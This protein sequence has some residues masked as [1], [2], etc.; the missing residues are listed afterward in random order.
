MITYSWQSSP[1]MLYFHWLKEEVS[2]SQ[3]RHKAMRGRKVQTA[4]GGGWSVSSD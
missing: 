1:F 2:L 3:R 4:I